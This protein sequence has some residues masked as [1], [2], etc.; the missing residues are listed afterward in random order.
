M[1]TLDPARYLARIGCESTW[2]DGRDLG[3]LEHLQQAHVTTIPFETLSITG[4]PFGDQDSGDVSLSVADIYEKIVVRHRGGF[5]YELN[6]LFGWLLD[7]L[8]FEVTYCSARIESDG[9]L[10][11]PADHLCL[12]VGRD[13]RYLVD[14]GLGLPKLRC[15]LPL[16]GGTLTDAAGIQWRIVE[17]ERPDADYALHYRESDDG[18]WTRRYILRDAPRTLRYFEA[19]CE[20]FVAAPESGF[21]GDPVVIIATERGHAKLSTTTVT[22]TVDRTTTE[23][24]IDPE[25]WRDVLE[26]EFN[27]QLSVN[28][29]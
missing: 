29:K 14:V 26:E 6:G 25:K 10:G 16:D 12:L 4:D 23:Q 21:T 9:E 28:T 2:I 8:G 19:T 13:E 1:D 27:V 24:S 17:S 11:P 22:R 3:T 5:C 7:E 20:Y 15:P 18:D